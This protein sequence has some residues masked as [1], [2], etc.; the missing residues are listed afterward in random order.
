MVKQYL[1]SKVYI[2]GKFSVFLLGENRCDER[3]RH[4]RGA[5]SP[6]PLFCGSGFIN[7][8]EKA[9]RLRRVRRTMYFIIYIEPPVTDPTREKK[10]EKEKK[11]Q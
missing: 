2:K 10:R 9:E 7:T 6:S 4:S 3:E 1:S 11:K 8:F 5:V